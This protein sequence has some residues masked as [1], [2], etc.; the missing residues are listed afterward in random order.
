[1]IRLILS[2]LIF[3]NISYANSERYFIKLGSFKNLRGLENSI[4]RLPHSLR[5]HVVIVHKNAW[6]IPFAYYV[7]NRR[8]LYKYVP[9]FQRYFPDAH[10]NHSAYM[11]DY[12]VVRNYS[13]P[14]RKHLPRYVRRQSTV[15]S[16]PRSSVQYSKP[17]YQNVA[18]S[19]ADNT[20]QMAVQRFA[21]APVANIV[22]NQPTIPMKEQSKKRYQSFSKKILSGKHYFLAYKSTKDSPSLLIKVSFKN[23][24]VVYQPIIGEMKMTEANY[25]IENK[26]LYMFANSFTKDGAY[27]ILDRHQKNYFLVSSWINGKK[28]NTLRYYF[29]L[30]DAKEYLNLEKSKGLANVLEEGSYDDFFLDNDY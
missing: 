14:K 18:I 26:R 8:I 12:P 25:I 29:N 27:S 9:K 6:Y 16:T 7:A 1:M 4:N 30:N 15:V 2:M 5:S 13:K 22:V 19:E 11:L 10:I 17:N 21:P 23:H 3:I 28:L 24:M 20:G